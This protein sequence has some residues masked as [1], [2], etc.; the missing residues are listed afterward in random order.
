MAEPTLRRIQDALGGPSRRQ[1]GI[2][3]GLVVLGLLL[4]GLSAVA[5]TLAISDANPAWWV[6]AV[7]SL[8]GAAGCALLALR[9]ILRARRARS[10]VE[11]AVEVPPEEAASGATVTVVIP[12]FCEA[13]Y[14]GAALES[15]QAQTYPWWR[16]VV[17]D[18]ESTDATSAVG[19]KY[20][21][22]DARISVLRLR[23]NSG[24]P[25]ARNAGLTQ[26]DTSYVLF[27][28]AD[29]ALFP[30]ALESRVTALVAD[31]TAAGA[32]GKVRQVPANADWRTEASRGPLGA[33]RQRVTLVTAGGENPFSIHEVLLRTERVL[34]LGG[35]TESLRSG[36]EDLDF[37]MRA[38]RSGREF[39]GTGRID[40]MYRQSPTSMV[41]VGVGAH[42]DNAL[43]LLDAAWRDQGCVAEVSHSP[44][45]DGDLGEI[46][47]RGMVE[48][49]LLRF[50]GMAVQ[51]GDTSASD[52]IVARLEAAAPLCTSRAS[53]LALVVAGAG[54]SLRRTAEGQAGAGLDHTARETGL[55]ALTSIGHLFPEHSGVPSPRRGHPSWAVLAEDRA[56]VAAMYAALSGLAPELRPVWVVSD[57]VDADMG[58]LTHLME[59][60]STAPWRSVPGYLLEGVAYEVLVLSRPIS[61]VA[62]MLDGE[63][64]ARGT[65]IRELD[66]PWS[67]AVAVDDD[68]TR[69]ARS[70]KVGAPAERVSLDALGCLGRPR[71]ELPRVRVRAVR[72]PL[73]GL[74]TK[75][76]S[77]GDYRGLDLPTTER[78]LALKDK[79]QGQRCVIIG[80]GPSLNRTDLAQLRG[81]PTFGVNGIYYAD[82]RLPESLTYYVVEDTKVFQENTADVLAYGRERAGTFVLPTLY[83]PSLGP[84]DTPVMFRMNGGFYRPTDPS[85]ARPRFSTNAVE[86]LYCGQSVTIINL[87]L[88]HWMGFSEV[89]LIGMD[90]SYAIP[91]GTHVQ[92]DVYTSAGDD[93]N[94]FD[95]RYF[96]AGKTWKDPKLNRVLANYELAK[97]IYE[98]DGR[99]IVNC[100]E[101]G[102]L[103]SF[104]RIAL[105]DFVRA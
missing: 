10:P 71:G 24:L 51:A 101:G 11:C 83:R 17:V 65:S 80:N 76:G 8:G 81:I 96:G 63:A 12:A 30:D 85:F 93:P 22:S 46:L 19:V 98:S 49:R 59:L 39:V 33:S 100:T 89:G 7:L 73:P 91:Q 13:A 43:N 47:R 56:Q 44:A 78:L 14:L 48:V 2:V 54:R 57:S 82:D 4:A 18:D 25:A 45:L 94:H 103:E 31:P 15:L 5:A 60:D 23:R 58:A 62:R 79:H 55:T 53:A 40:C 75:D 104:E 64:R 28:D 70:H 72:R 87:Q 69:A 67:A 86:V 105:A 35:F 68:E 42:V 36:A 20:G 52:A 95:S 66:L 61:W 90:F 38:L 26:V 9:R 92:G 88:A 27:L 32:Y 6:S 77:S 21:A 74:A 34:E 29:D 1:A 50:L 37:W 16:A 41:A 97:A 102:A 99:R 3:V 84:D